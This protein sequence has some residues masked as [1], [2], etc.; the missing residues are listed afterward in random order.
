M[1]DEDF[2]D[3]IDDFEGEI[4]GYCCLCCGHDQEDPGMGWTCDRCM[5]PLEEIYE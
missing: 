2:Y 3:D 5:G 4:I 1:N